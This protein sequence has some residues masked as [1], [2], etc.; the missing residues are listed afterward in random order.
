MVHVTRLQKPDSLARQS[1]AGWLSTTECVCAG[2]RLGDLAER[3]SSGGVIDPVS[4]SSRPACCGRPLPG[5][6]D[7]SNGNSN[8]GTRKKIK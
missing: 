8:S 2:T 4:V 5:G 1:C 7:N 3:S 6:H